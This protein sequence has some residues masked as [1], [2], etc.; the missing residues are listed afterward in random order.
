MQARGLIDEDFRPTDMLRGHNDAEVAH[1][2]SDWSILPEKHRGNKLLLRDVGYRLW[3]HVRQR[4]SIEVSQDGALELYGDSRALEN[5][6]EDWSRDWP[7]GEGELRYRIPSL[8]YRYPFHPFLDQKHGP[9]TNTLP[10]S[11]DFFAKG[12]PLVDPLDQ[13]TTWLRAPRRQRSDG[14][15]DVL[16]P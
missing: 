9:A 11:F 6:R 1:H 13:F 5:I 15:W 4:A 14:M 3:D 8:G 2:L 16:L 7:G 10:S 12:S